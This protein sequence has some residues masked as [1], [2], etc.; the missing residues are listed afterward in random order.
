MASKTNGNSDE[1]MAHVREVLASERWLWADG[2]QGSDG[3][4]GIDGRAA[5]ERLQQMGA[6]SGLVEDRQ[7]GRI[8]LRW[9]MG[10]RKGHV[11]RPTEC[12][13]TYV[14]IWLC[15]CLCVCT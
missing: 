5:M 11:W 6:V 2:W 3:G 8:A 13:G 14:G 9:T 12:A 1:E 4:K 15:L 7:P 10:G